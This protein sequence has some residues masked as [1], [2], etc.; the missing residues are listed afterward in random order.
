MNHKE[1]SELIDKL[2]TENN[3]II[4][5][6]SIQNELR[7]NLDFT[8]SKAKEL[9]EKN[10]KFNFLNI[11]TELNKRYEEIIIKHQIKAN[12]KTN[13]TK[14]IEQFYS[15]FL[16]ML[17]ELTLDK[18]EHKNLS[19]KLKKLAQ[20]EGL[21]PEKTDMILLKEAIEIQKFSDNKNIYIISNDKDLYLF[22]KEIYEKYKI[23]TKK[24]A[25]QLI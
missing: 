23:K 9:C 6:N 2:E 12:L 18:I 19:Q 22:N 21:L 4:I 17:Y 7:K 24:I 10:N 3:K 15:N 25:L 16:E 11:R 13:D 5:T 1:C 14:E 20:R 8:L